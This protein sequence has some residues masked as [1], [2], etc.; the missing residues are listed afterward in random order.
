MERNSTPKIIWLFTLP[1]RERDAIEAD[2][3]RAGWTLDDVPYRLSWRALFAFLQ[4]LGPESAYMRVVEPELSFWLG[5]EGVP[6]LLAT[7]VDIGNTQIWQ[8]TKDGA[9]NRRRP[10]PIKRPWN[11]ANVKTVGQGAIPKSHWADFWGDGS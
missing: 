4:H 1:Q 10:K 6:N 9:K 2:L 5:S 11:K 3:V 8:K 7:L